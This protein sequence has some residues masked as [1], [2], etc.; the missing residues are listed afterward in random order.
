MKFQCKMRVSYMPDCKVVP[1][2]NVNLK[3]IFIFF[4]DENLYL[5]SIDLHICASV[6]ST[7]VPA[8]N[9]KMLERHFC[10]IYSWKR[11][12]SK[13]KCHF[14]YSLLSFGLTRENRVYNLVFWS[15]KRVQIGGKPYFQVKK[16]ILVL[17]LSCYSGDWQVQK[18]W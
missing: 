5:L 13:L 7:N 8:Q 4:L 14:I 12:Y 16:L 9:I 1:R 15:P 3:K 11:M 2:V 10:F 17:S 18:Y 6:G